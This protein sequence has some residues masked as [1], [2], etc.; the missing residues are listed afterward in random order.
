MRP[1]PILTN[2][3]NLQNIA[4]TLN[5]QMST[6]IP[7]SQSSTNIL[8]RV[9][10]TSNTTLNSELSNNY[11]NPRVITHLTPELRVTYNKIMEIRRK[12]IYM[13]MQELFMEIDQL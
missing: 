9:Q 7:R 6:T 12:P 3:F 8:E 11:Y 2:R 10:P 5:G 4:N 13:R 1:H